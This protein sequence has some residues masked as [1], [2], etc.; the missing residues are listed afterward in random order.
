[1][2][3]E[4]SAASRAIPDRTLHS[5]R[6]VAPAAGL[7]VLSPVIAEC[8]LGNLT[9][10]EMPVVMPLLAPMYGGGAVLIRETTRRAGRGP[11]T[12]LLLGAAYGLVEEGLVDQLLFNR[13]YAGRDLL[14]D[15]YI[16][17]LG[18]GGWLTIAAPTLH[19]VW[20]IAVPIALVEHLVPDRAT[21]PWLRNGGLAGVVLVYVA[22]CALVGFGT[23]T[24]ERFLAAPAQLTVTAVA[25]VALVFAA[26]AARPSMTIDA[27]AATPPPLRVGAAALLAGAA[28]RASELLSGWS[29]AALA[30]TVVGASSV[31]VGRWSRSPSWDESHRFA[32]MAGALTCHAVAGFFT[33][34]EAAPKRAREYAAST[35]LAAGAI[36]LLTAAMGK[37]GIRRDQFAFGGSKSGG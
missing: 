28:F 26:F 23:Y 11:A 24:D 10:A 22:G 36:G 27:R 25:A 33:Q 15:T 13:T 16:P 3:S 35:L 17:V 7:F 37:L 29:S 9:V 18:I 4:S 1:M 8:L 19:A 32:L 31:T 6:R 2:V 34:P 20:S 21:V 12:V 5:L 30:A 14:G